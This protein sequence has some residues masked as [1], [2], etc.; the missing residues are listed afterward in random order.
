METDYSS[1]ILRSA[2][3]GRHLKPE[4]NRPFADAG[5]L[6]PAGATPN[7]HLVAPCVL[8]RFAGIARIERGEGIGGLGL[9]L[10]ISGIREC[11]LCLY[12][13]GAG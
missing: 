12:P 1:Q 8:G 13:A 6:P 3:T 9:I 10:E 2:V 4:I 11:S 5:I 7:Q